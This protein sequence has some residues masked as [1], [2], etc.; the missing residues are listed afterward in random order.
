MSTKTYESNGQH[1]RL[2]FPGDGPNHVHD[3]YNS[4]TGIMGSHGENAS[5]SDK[6]WSGQRTNE[7]M[8]HGDW[9]RGV[10]N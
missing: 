1:N 2:E 3:F 4:R 10:K 7:T 5:A 8:T 9:T 6:Q